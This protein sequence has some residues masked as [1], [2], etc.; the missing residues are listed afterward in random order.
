ME[1]QRDIKRRS[2]L[3]KTVLVAVAVSV[4]GLKACKDDDNTDPVGID[5]ATTKDI[6]GPFYKAGAPYQENIIPPEN[7]AAPLYITGKVSGNCN[8]L[9]EDA[10]VEIWNANT[11]G[12]YDISDAYK[13]RGQFRTEADGLYR[14]KTIIPGKYLNG[15]NYRPS[16]IHFRITATG[17]NELV[18]Q[19]YFKDDPFLTQDPWAADP[20]ATGRILPLG[21]DEN[22]T[23]TITFDIYLTT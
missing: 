23:D 3:K 9:I 17:Y 12:I 21:K 20:S 11:E 6:L 14:F 19:I 2:F 22:G 16:H 7:E 13:F 5:C 10:I 1:R 8:T 15:A 18:S 4:S